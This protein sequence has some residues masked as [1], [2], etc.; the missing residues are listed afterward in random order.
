MFVWQNEIGLDYRMGPD[1]NPT[2]LRALFECL[3]QLQQIAPTMQVGLPQQDLLEMRE[4][5]I[6]ALQR[7]YI[8]WLT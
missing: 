3:Y 6:E 2:R 1:W 7:Y 5:F 8:E 4:R